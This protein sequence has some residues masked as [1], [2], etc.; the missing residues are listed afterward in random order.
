MPTVAMVAISQ[1]HIRVFHLETNNAGDLNRVNSLVV[2][3]SFNTF[4]PWSNAWSYRR[5][6][7]FYN[8]AVSLGGIHKIDYSVLAIVYPV[9]SV[10]FGILSKSCA[11]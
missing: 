6:S 4:V 5:N 2:V 3:A 9:V 7:E 8:T 10:F 11:I 1:N